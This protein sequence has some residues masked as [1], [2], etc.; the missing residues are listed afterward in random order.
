MNLQPYSHAPPVIISRFYVRGLE[1][2]PPRR[3]PFQTRSD[4]AT[5]RIERRQKK[6]SSSP[7]PFPF[8]PI[9]FAIGG[10]RIPSRPQAKRNYRIPPAT[11]TNLG[12]TT[13]YAREFYCIASH[14]TYHSVTSALKEE[15]QRSPGAKK[16]LEVRLEYFLRPLPA[17][18]DRR[19]NFWVL[20]S[21]LGRGKEKIIDRPGGQKKGDARANRAEFLIP[22]RE[23]F[24]N[25][26]FPA[27][28]ACMQEIARKCEQAC[29]TICWL[30]H[31]FFIVDS[32]FPIQTSLHLRNV[33]LFVPVS[34]F[35]CRHIKDCK[36]GPF[37]LAFPDR[38]YDISPSL[39]PH[40]AADQFTTECTSHKNGTPPLFESA[41]AW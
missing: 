41:G 27:K 5:T 36:K 34:P 17:T 20:R 32:R 7:S 16:K 18:L 33:A 8:N 21:S 24:H 19:L 11:A 29:R 6:L 40:N 39:L 37:R 15:T 2:S 28:C 38:D 26:L 1:R 23:Q 9:E 35:P 12:A 13:E 25:H 4:G 30:F 22:R 31:S 14:T 10:D 3:M